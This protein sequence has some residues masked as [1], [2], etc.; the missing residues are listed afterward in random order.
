MRAARLALRTKTAGVKEGPGSPHSPAL[1]T[2]KENASTGDSWHWGGSPLR[3]PGLRFLSPSPAIAHGVG[4]HLVPRRAP[5]FSAAP[6]V[7]FLPFSFPAFPVGLAAPAAQYRLFTT[8][9]HPRHVL[10][11]PH[12][13][14]PRSTLSLHIPRRVTIESTSAACAPSSPDGLPS[15]IRFSSAPRHSR[16]HHT[17]QHGH[18]HLHGNVSHPPSPFIHNR[19]T[20]S[21][22]PTTTCG[23]IFFIFGHSEAPEAPPR[24]A[25]SYTMWHLVI[26]PHPTRAQLAR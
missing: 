15:H 11:R 17:I 25:P 20:S 7:P 23:G 13:R 12:H 1:L 4:R 21:I 10:F 18:A 24:L 26:S 22:V 3:S 6:T 5:P 14:P 16:H 8:L 9:H 2:D 19:H